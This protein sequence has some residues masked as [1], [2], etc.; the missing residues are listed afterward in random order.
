MPSNEQ[1]R[2]HFPPR[3]QALWP[4]EASI[5]HSTLPSSGTIESSSNWAKFIANIRA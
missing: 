2:L 3:R 5:P 1:V 4:V